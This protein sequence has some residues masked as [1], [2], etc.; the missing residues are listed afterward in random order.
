M[1]HKHNV[2]DLPQSLQSFAKEILFKQSKLKQLKTTDK[3]LLLG[4][5]DYSFGAALCNLGL[6]FKNSIDISFL[7][8]FR[9]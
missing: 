9:I 1:A 2:K 7:F 4:E 3:I 8:L 5:G 6:Y